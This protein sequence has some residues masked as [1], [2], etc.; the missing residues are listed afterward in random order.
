VRRHQV[1]DALVAL[2]LA[3]WVPH[4]ADHRQE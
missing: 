4:G 1:N 2:A 3:S